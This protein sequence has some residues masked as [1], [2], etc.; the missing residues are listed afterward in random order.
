MVDVELCQL[1]FSIQLCHKPEAFT[2]MS[3]S[4][5]QEGLGEKETEDGSPWGGHRSLTPAQASWELTT[6]HLEAE[7]ESE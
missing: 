6:V 7:A 2:C 4:H 1:R 3:Q 5:G